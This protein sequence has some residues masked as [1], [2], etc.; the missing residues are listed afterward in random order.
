MKKFILAL[1]LLVV[2]TV[3][4]FAAA[5]KVK[6]DS[7]AYP[8]VFFMTDSTDHVTGKTGLS[9]TVTI[10]KPA[11]SFASPS[12]AVT[13]IANGWYQVAGNA[14]DTSTLGPLLL[15]ATA[16]GADPVDM[17]YE[18]V[19]VDPQDSTPPMDL[20]AVDGDTFPSAEFADNII[21]FFNNNGVGSTRE[22][23]ELAPS[24]YNV[25]VISTSDDA[26]AVIEAQSAGTLCLL[27]PGTHAMGAD[28][29]VIPDGVVVQGAGRDVTTLTST[30]TSPTICVTP[31]DNSRICDLTIHSLN[32]SDGTF[33]FPL[34]CGGSATFTNAVMQNLRIIGRTDGVY[35]STTGDCSG[36][37]DDILISTKYDGWVSHNVGTPPEHHFTVRDVRI[38]IVEDTSVNTAQG[39]NFGGDSLST[40]DVSNLQVN[41]QCTPVTGTNAL[42]GVRNGAGTRVAL[43]NS[44]IAFIGTATTTNQ[45]ILVE[46][47][48]GYGSITAIN[49]EFDRD[50]VSAAQAGSFVDILSPIQSTVAFRKV[51]VE[52]TG[53]VGL[54]FDNVKQAASPTTLTNITIP[55][56]TTTATTTNLTNL[57]TIPANWITSAGIATDAIGSD[58]VAA[59]GATEI[60]GGLL[61]QVH[62]DSV[63]D[64][65]TTL[66]DLY[67]GSVLEADVAA[68][69]TDI[70]AVPTAAEI[71]ANGT[72]SL[73]DKADF[74][75]ATSQTFSTTGSVGSVTSAI[76]L[77]TIPTNWITATGIA[78]DAIDADAIAANAI[79]ATEAPN[80]DTTVSSRLASGSYT[81]PLDAAG[82][83]SAVGLSTNNLDT[84]L[85]DIPTAAEIW[86][87]ATRSLTDK[88]GFSLTQAFP[89]N[90]ED[91]A[92]TD[93]T[94]QVT[95]GT[96]NDKTGYALTQTFP[97]NF[98]DLAIAVGTG[99]VTTDSVTLSPEDID[100][101]ADA[102]ATAV[103]GAVAEDVWTYA[104]RDLT[105]KTGF[106][107]T[108]AFPTNFEDMSITD[109]TGQVTVG[110][111]NDK[112]GYSLS[113]AFPAGFS[114]WTAP[115][116]AA[117]IRSA[118]GLST[119]N[120]DTQLADI[121]TVSEFNARTL[122]SA[123]Y[124]TATAVDDI[125]TTAE[126]NARS[127]LAA[128]YATATAVDDIPTVSE[129][130]AR[131]LVAADYATASAL[132]AVDNYVDTEI[133]TLI[134]NTNNIE[135]DTQNIQTRLPAALV[136]GKMDSVADV[137]FELSPEDIQAI[138]DGTVAAIGEG[139]ISAEDIWTYANR[140]LTEAP[141]LTV[142]QD[143]WLEAINTRVLLAL[144]AAAS[145]SGSGLATATNVDNAEPDLT[146]ITTALDDI[147]GAGFNETFDSLDAIRTRIDLTPL[148][149]SSG[150]GVL[151][152]RIADSTLS[153]KKYLEII[154][155]EEKAIT[156]I[157]DAIGRF[158]NAVATNIE[159]K[160]R[161]AGKGTVPIITIPNEDIV[162][163]C[164]E[165]DVQVFRLVL[166]EEQTAM[167]NNGVATIEITFDL[168]KALLKQS[169]K[170]VSSL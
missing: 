86:A 75:L 13:E 79:T 40:Y 157:V 60:Q 152:A 55:N 66:D 9:P 71:W 90:F 11:G 36:T 104:T 5:Y 142:E 167:L 101:I 7:A 88:T 128:S 159:V 74:S 117:G 39:C 61:T 14:T 94:G 64:T 139:L 119:G 83:R 151:E 87:N 125:P 10:R 162:R 37:F 77:P 70:D 19:A 103:G 1:L 58:E 135:T 27:T 98:A 129:F 91:M 80:L 116:D 30:V 4:C 113:Q 99:A 16:T 158:D 23:D 148:T 137:A 156:F 46:T 160:I 124:A 43:H 20:L 34:G 33:D 22:L 166:D 115:L 73:T 130:N 121:P 84:Q 26:E 146:A 93:T 49:C 35:I 59:T 54:N 45:S 153:P 138:V 18:V 95:V 51:D 96:N 154:Q 6:E 24:P 53:E 29:L 161:S 47:D 131:T 145:G 110:T 67:A 114:S 57:P 8:L 81:A 163:L 107:L 42:I 164:E 38:D 72:R 122:A 12:G 165:L 62:F 102:T 150:G 68:I 144:P 25:V 89:T 41:L 105:V 132:D 52:S 123:S 140:S 21:T 15:H 17:I 63:I 170:I 106:S 3:Q 127:L 136:G 109:T 82:V 143:G 118:V 169:L 2:T 133:G 168:Q 134:T 112:T 97:A 141:G 155:G 85:G 92:I 76:T 32:T 31:G 126:F 28:A 108:Q 56:V 100:A 50:K 147:K 120:L 149:G 44:S 69:S 65:N 48:N 78:T 111:N